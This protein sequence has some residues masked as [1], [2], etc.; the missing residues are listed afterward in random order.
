[1][2]YEGRIC[3]T[4]GEKASFKLPVSVGCPYNACSF[5]D[6][7]T[8]LEYRELPF[9]QID[10][11]LE[12]V[13][14]AGG[15]PKRVMLGD[16]NA[17]WMD[18]ER[19]ARIVEA[20]NTRLPSV[21]IIASDASVPAIAAKTDEQLKWLAERGYTMVYIGI[22]SGL[23]DVL[24]FMH[25]DHNNDQARAQIAR[26]HNAGISYGAHIMTGVAG[27]GRGNEN[28]RA[29]AALLNETRPVFVNNFSMNVA[30]HTKLGRMEKNGE[31]TRASVLECL[32]E[33]RTLLG[34]LDV[35]ARFE[36]FHFEYDRSQVD[37][38]TFEGSVSEFNSYVTSW[39]HT[40]GQLPAD[41][42][43]LIA[44]LDGAI[45]AIRKDNSSAA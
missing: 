24:S 44:K 30:P 20:I 19:L 14:S 34:L 41:R 45:A 28:A 12:R 36:G 29:T 15:T 18:F 32:E 2:D 42:E 37:C 26:L 16:G 13:Q 5:C 17:F 3:Q 1:M 11:E 27:A 6:L 9:E 39:T 4:P 21:E 25:K 7:F 35:E 22:E 8:D 33:E 31:F 40:F 23:D 10:V 43:S 38:A